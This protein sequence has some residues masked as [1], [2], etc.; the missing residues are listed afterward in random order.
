MKKLLIILAF[1]MYLCGGNAQCYY[2]NIYRYDENSQGTDAGAALLAIS[3]NNIITTGVVA[4]SASLNGFG[5]FTVKVN[6]CGDT[7]LQKAYDYSPAGAENGIA[8]IEVDANNLSI[9]GY[10]VDT[11]QGKREGFIMFIDTFGEVLSRKTLD[12]GKINEIM[13][14]GLLLNDGIIAGGYFNETIDS[15]LFLIK[16]DLQGN[17]QW[18]KYY[19]I[20][21]TSLRTMKNFARAKDGGYII[22][23]TAF[24][25][26]GNSNLFLLKTDSIGNKEWSKTYPN[27]F[28]QGG[29]AATLDGGYMLVGNSNPSPNVYNG[30]VGKMN[31]AGNVLWEKRFTNSIDPNV[32]VQILQLSDSN[33]LVSGSVRPTP[34][35]NP[36]L[37]IAKLSKDSGTVIW[38]RNYTYH[39]ANSHDYIEK[40]ILTDEGD[41]VGTGYIIPPN[42]PPLP[43][44]YGNDMF[45]IKLDSCGYLESD[46]I[47]ADFSL[48]FTNANTIDF[49]N[50][51]QHFCSSIW[52]F[53]DGKGGNDFSPTHT[54]TDTGTYTVTLV[55]NAGNSTDIVSQ[56][57]HVTGPSGVSYP[58]NGG[59]G[60]YPNPAKDNV[61]IN[62]QGLAVD[63]Y[64]VCDLTGR[65]VLNGAIINHRQTIDIS[66]ISK[67]VYLLRVT[68]KGKM[69]GNGKVVKE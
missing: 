13:C 2:H 59:V 12:A 40:M 65:V 39:G 9:V 17:I 5:A 6:Q 51:S 7:L 14:D 19:A 16:T 4:N 29:V 64:V 28:Y 23:G 67:G 32:I 38:Q 62:T 68:E 10:A 31:S 44:Y 22:G 53:G 61:I 41:I 55:V 57:V 21:G 8:L 11:L 43:V 45:I 69:V 56:Q 20:A 26:G 36:N 60:F 30:Y 54:Y 48:Q 66:G 47:K 35:S 63:A 25:S 42:N 27:T 24:F 33:Y 49:T 18:T 3:G 46:S 50:L 15:N 1:V 37:Y 34:S 58:S 52:Y